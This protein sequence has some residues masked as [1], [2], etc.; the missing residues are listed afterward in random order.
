M[1]EFLR[2]FTDAA[3]LH[4]DRMAYFNSRMWR[5]EDPSEESITYG[6]LD[7]ASNAA[8]AFFRT[9]VPAGQP[10]VVYGHKSPLML[11]AFLGAVKAGHPYAPID[12]A[13]PSARVN[14]IMEQIGRPLVVSLVDGEFPGDPSL[15]ARLVDK[16]QFRT[17]AS[18][19]VDGDSQFWVS[20]EDGFYLLFTSGSTGRPKGVMMPS[21]GVDAFMGYFISLFPAAAQQGC[22][23]PV[24]SFNRVPYTF[25]VS[26]FDIIPGLSHGMTLFGLEEEDEASMALS[27]EAFRKS[28]AAVWISTPSYMDM[29]LADRS[30]SQELMPRLESIILCGE[31]FRNDTARQL[32][33]RFPNARIYN[34]YGPTETQAVTDIELDSALV[35]SLDPLPVGHLGIGSGAVILDLE[36]GE[37]LGAGEV[38]EIY[39][40]GDT[41]S[42]GYYGRD[43]LTAAAF[44]GRMLADGRKARCYKTG[45][46][47]FLD[48]EGR[49]YCLG[50]LD[51]QIKLNGFRVELGEVER[52]L[53]DLEG[54]ADAVVL[55]AERGGKIVSLTAH[56]VPVDADAPRDFAAGKAIKEQLKD[57]LPAY[58]IPKKVVFHDAFPLNTNGKTDRKALAEK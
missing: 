28:D 2:K 11:V 21:R 54:V 39:L 43:D 48:E 58:M 12:I 16:A 50:R 26:L 41:V 14:D 13:Y 17:I 6:G 29:C 56:V 47:G 30:F 38:G 46:R 52:A 23:E 10:I 27:F 20:G 25:D 5:D 15:A 18:Q 7:R 44:Q 31:V 35:E 51:N 4:P 55:P 32:L 37:E 49:L 19:P 42:L 1:S 45:D 57:G 9:T 8:A 22:S 3:R 34:T 33:E 24:V 53:L 40:Y 36:T